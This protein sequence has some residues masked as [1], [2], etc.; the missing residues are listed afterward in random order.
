MSRWSPSLLIALTITV[1][2]HVL[3]VYGLWQLRTSEPVKPVTLLS[4]QWIDER[5]EVVTPPP[6]VETPPPA[7]TEP[8]DEPEPVMTQDVAPP[9]PPVE[10]PKPKPK[11]KVKPKPVVQQPV[12]KTVPVAEPIKTPVPAEAPVLPK[13]IPEAPV[14]TPAQ[15]QPMVQATADYLN[16]PKPSYPRVSKRL[17]EQGEVRLKVQVGRDGQVLSLQLAQTSGYDRLDD[18]AMASVK[19]WRFKPAMRG[20]EAVVSWVEVPVK[21]VLE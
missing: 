13:P 7:P 18:A 6:A 2:L 3:L 19:Q 14:S 12:P 21:F 17:G 16:N 1:V 20:N 4:M 9:P 8:V 10:K 11:P 15:E 5:P